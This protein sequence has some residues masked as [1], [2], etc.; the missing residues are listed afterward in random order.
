MTGDERN[1]Y[2]YLPRITW[3][4]SIDKMQRWEKID[5]HGRIYSMAQVIHVFLTKILQQI[6]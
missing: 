3:I 1:L 5:I 4:L 6:K 2:A